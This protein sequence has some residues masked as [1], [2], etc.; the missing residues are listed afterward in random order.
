MFRCNKCIWIVALNLGMIYCKKRRKPN[1]NLDLKITDQK[2]EKRTVVNKSI[3]E[4]WSMW[5]T[6]EGAKRLFGA[7][8]KIELTPMGAYEIYFDDSAVYGLKGSETCQVLS[9]LPAQMVSFTWNAPP[10]YED[11]RNHQYRTWVVVQM[12][13]LSSEQTE[14]ELIHLGWPQGERWQLVQAYFINA[15]DY[16]FKSMEK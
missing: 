12:K 13:A 16:V 15:W 2:I 5:T 3:D 9:F 11:I 8:N 7:E 4:V 6:Y 10:K 1:M 14:V